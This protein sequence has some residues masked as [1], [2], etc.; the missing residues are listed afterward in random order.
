MAEERDSKEL[1]EAS[2]SNDAQPAQPPPR[3]VPHLRQR[4]RP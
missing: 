3:K 1:S 4:T 2:A